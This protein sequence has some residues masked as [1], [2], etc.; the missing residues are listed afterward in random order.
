ME[1]RKGFLTREIGSSKEVARRN[2]KTE[3][4]AFAENETVEWKKN[5]GQT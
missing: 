5:G 2:K 1:G 4:R 3:W